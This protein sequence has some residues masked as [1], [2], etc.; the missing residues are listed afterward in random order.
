MTVFAIQTAIEYNGRRG[1]TMTLELNKVT[2]Q[3]EEMGQVLAERAERRQRALPAAHALLRHFAHQQEEL[4][5]VAESEAGRRWRCASPG[6]EPLDASYATPDLP[7]RVTLIAADGSQIYPDRHGLAFYYAINVGSVVFRH[8][9]AQAPDVG[10]QPRLFYEEKQVYPEGR[11]I[12]SDLVSVQRDLSEMRALADLALA[13]PSSGPPRLA[14]ADGS[15]LIWLQRAA[16]PEGQRV[17]ILEGYL[18]CLDQ[19]QTDGA[20]VAGFVSRPQSAE[21]VALLYLAHLEPE[22]RMLK[23][24]LAGTDYEG[25]ADRA[26]FGYLKPGERSALFVRGTASNE[27][28]QARGHTVYFFYLNTGSELARVEVPEWVVHRPQRLNLVHAA[29]QEQCRFNNGYPYVLTRAD[30]QAVILNEEREALEGMIMQAMAR[31]GL[32][33]P[34]LSRKAQQKQVARWRRR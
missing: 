19:L 26:L 15:L 14:L 9:S 31:N 17:R 1:Q 8:G 33:M 13:E 30:E 27:D 7:Q 5:R 20:M 3:V 10:T 2:R 18:T 16:I 6:N 23:D 21:V 29:V 32:P 25:L 24:G 34:E 12:T 4:R 11:L 22:E 28:F